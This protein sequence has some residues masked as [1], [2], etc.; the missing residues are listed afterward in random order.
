MNI[1]YTHTRSQK[2]KSVWLSTK[3]VTIRN[4]QNENSD[5]FN[6]INIFKCDFW[7]KAKDRD[8]KY[9]QNTYLQH[10]ATFFLSCMTIIIYMVKKLMHA[11]VSAKNYA[12]EFYKYKFNENVNYKLDSSCICIW[13]RERRSS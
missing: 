13:I 12:K 9:I 5:D 1:P 2:K 3:T 10:S 11:R 6:Y 4:Q 8:V 7:A